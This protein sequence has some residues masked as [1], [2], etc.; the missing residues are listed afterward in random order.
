MSDVRFETDD[1]RGLRLEGTISP[2]QHSASFR[3]QV[4]REGGDTATFRLSLPPH[5]AEQQ[6]ITLSAPGM[7]LGVEGFPDAKPATTQ[8]GQRI[9]GTARRLHQGEAQLRELV[10]TLSGIPGPGPARWVA[11]ALAAF[12]ALGGLL[13][14]WQSRVGRRSRAA[15]PASRRPMPS[16]PRK[17]CS[18]SSSSWRPRDPSRTSVPRPTK[19]PEGR[20]W[21]RLL[22]LE[23]SL[24]SLARSASRD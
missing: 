12:V 18:A 11:S 6:V 15:C 20:C 5:V 9:L 4:P 7:S 3:F 13:F 14:A 23:A 8:N 17:S 1:Q 21:R 16:R 19:P 24:P 10:I 2:G 22:R